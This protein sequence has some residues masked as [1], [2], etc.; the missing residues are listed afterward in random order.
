MN[1]KLWRKAKAICGTRSSRKYGTKTRKLKERPFG[2][3]REQY[4]LLLANKQR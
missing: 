3:I 1:G 4:L 2:K